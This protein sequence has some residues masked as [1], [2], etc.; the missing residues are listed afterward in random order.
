MSLIIMERGIFKK[1][2]KKRTRVVLFIVLAVFILAA[3]YYFL[4]HKIN[5]DDALCF[6]KAMESCSKAS[7]I[8]ED[9]KA[10][11]QYVITGETEDNCGVIVKL[12]QIKSGSIDNQ[13]L[14][15]KSMNCEIPRTEKDFPEKQISR[16]HGLLKEELQNLIIQRMHS[17][18][19]ENIGQIEQEFGGI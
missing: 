15:G 1:P 3:A 19:L 8:K 18:L 17:Y 14:E 11:W 5:C 7:W 12:L 6:S 9:A 4:F 13:V 10:S 16:C 2:A